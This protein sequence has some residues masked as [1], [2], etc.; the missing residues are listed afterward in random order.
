MTA[1]GEPSRA[2]HEPPTRQPPD[3]CAAA[4]GGHCMAQVSDEIVT[5][6]DAVMS[7]CNHRFSSIPLSHVVDSP[8]GP[9]GEA[10]SARADEANEPPVDS[11]RR[12]LGAMAA[13]IARRGGVLNSRA[14]RPHLALHGRV[15]RAARCGGVESGVGARIRIDRP[16]LELSALGPGRGALRRPHG[17]RVDA[18][19]LQL[20]PELASPRAPWYARARATRAQPRHQA[21]AP[22]KVQ[23]FVSTS[24]EARASRCKRRVPPG[25]APWRVRFG[26][27]RARA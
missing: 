21:R 10:S 11:G 25:G 8:R 5:C 13:F 14:C 26:R 2:Q 23:C 16:A 1:T 18:L 3:E 17:A 15:H 24:S 22:S 9:A 20:P 4:V 27:R 19:Q 6:K 7:V 12:R